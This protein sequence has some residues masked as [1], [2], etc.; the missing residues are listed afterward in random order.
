AVHDLIVH[1][2]DNDLIIAT[3]GRSIYVL[4]DATPV[5]QMTPEVA[6]AD[7]YL[8]EPRPA[9]RYTTRMTR[10]GVAEKAF[11]AQNPPYG[12][13]LSYYLKAKPDE[14]TK[15][16]FQILD[17][18]GKTVS[19]IENVAKEP[20]IN[21]VNWNLRYGG[22]QVRRPPT[23]E[24]TQFTGGPRGPQVLP[25][26]YTVR[27]LVGAKTYERKV[28]VRLDPTVSVPAADLRETLD[29]SL[30][31]RDMQTATNN[32]LRTLD[33]LKAQIEFVERTVRD[34]L[35]AS[36]VPKELTDRL[37]AQKKRV[38]E[39]QNR[40]A[41][42]EGGLGFEGRAQLVDRI[43]GLFFTLDATNAGPT[44]AARELYG[45]LQKEFNEK[46]GEV[47]AFLSDSVPQLNEAL[48]RTGAPTL[49]TGKP[50]ELPKP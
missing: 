47:N 24:E 25:G 26:T 36:D 8:F 43:G 37:A 21:R 33:S 10:Y 38:E 29:M 34:R 13:L 14:K 15:V 30:R 46:I 16:R 3:H 22:P 42:P 49:M 18:A 5:Q 1:P 12:A 44:P 28:E 27:L 19:E 2:R 11:A 7:A 45:D 35:A 50:I 31:L 32:A 9:L 17:A 23:D 41:Q 48:R 4:D 20:G 6:S 39:L 40:L